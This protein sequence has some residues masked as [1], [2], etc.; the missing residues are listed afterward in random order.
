MTSTKNKFSLLTRLLLIVPAIVSILLVVIRMAV[1]IYGSDS[2]FIR[3]FIPLTL[4]AINAYV[5][6]NLILKKRRMLG[7]YILIASHLGLL[8]FLLMSDNYLYPFFDWYSPVEII[9]AFV[10]KGIF[11][12]GILFLPNYGKSGWEM[13]RR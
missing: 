5:V 9:A 13:L 8:T 2:S 12:V 3:Y 10:I 4:V 11:F 7:V 6:I 1:M